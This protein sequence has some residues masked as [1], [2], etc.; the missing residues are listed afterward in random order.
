M[1]ESHELRIL[2]VLGLGVVAIVA[3]PTGA[4]IGSLLRWIGVAVV[5]WLAVRA[6]GRR[7]GGGRPA[8]R[9]TPPTGGEVGRPLRGREA[10]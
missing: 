3:I 9:Q 1:M 10:A 4:A 2:F 5:P 8:S 7:R 6:G